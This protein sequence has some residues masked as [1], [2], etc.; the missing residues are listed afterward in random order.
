MANALANERQTE[1]KIAPLAVPLGRYAR[2]CQEPSART[3]HLSLP[4]LSLNQPSSMN[5]EGRIQ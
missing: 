5:A 3:R 1:A 4:G 2:G